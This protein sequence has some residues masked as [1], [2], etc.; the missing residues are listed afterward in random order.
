[1]T[2]RVTGATGTVGRL[3]V[4]HLVANG[5]QHVRALTNNPAQA[6]LPAEVEVVQ[7]Y[8]GR[9]ETL[10]DALAGVE[11]LYL[12]PLPRTAREVLAMAKQA[13]VQRVVALSSGGP[14]APRPLES[15][16]EGTGYQEA[17]PVEGGR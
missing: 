4:D 10:P 8:L 3:V 11:R 15:R 13:G 5:A 7:G 9:L 17:P 6:A 12:A 2:I 14:P 16:C 1:M